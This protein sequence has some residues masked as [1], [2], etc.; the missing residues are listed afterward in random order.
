MKDYP[1]LFNDA[2][3][4]AY[5]A[6]RKTQMRLPVPDQPGDGIDAQHGDDL[7]NR[8]P[9]E[10]RDDEDEYVGMGFRD[11]DRWWKSPFG[12]PGD[13][14]WV[15]E[16]WR[17]GGSY[18]DLT[19]KQLAEDL[20]AI[21]TVQENHL[22]YRADEPERAKDTKWRPSIHM[23]KWACRTFLP[24]LDVRVERI[25]DITEEDAI[26]EGMREM[27]SADLK[28]GWGAGDVT[29]PPP[30]SGYT[31]RNAFRRTW[32]TIYATKCFGWDANPL[33]WVGKFKSP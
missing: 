11:D 17:M 16:C 21:S 14:L 7:R 24:V 23:P 8:A 3:V 20:W 1:V 26:A 9:Y 13:R 5:R 4:R 29:P 33:V 19:M 30:T 18:S 28:S 10:I 15:R 27:V 32:D 2:M 12:G 22:H 6:G 31:Y 25:Q